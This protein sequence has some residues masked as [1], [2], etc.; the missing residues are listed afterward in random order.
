MF[1]GLY[2]KSGIYVR[3]GCSFK[4]DYFSGGQL[5]ETF[6]KVRNKKELV[7]DD[8]VNADAMIESLLTPG[9]K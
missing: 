8:E 6:L 7:N 1:F 4:S 9:M 3:V 5:A 2:S